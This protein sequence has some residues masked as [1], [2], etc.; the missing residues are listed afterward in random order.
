QSSAWCACKAAAMS[1]A[2]LGAFQPM[3]LH[4]TCGG[5]RLPSK[6]SHSPLSSPFASKNRRCSMLAGVPYVACLVPCEL[7]TEGSKNVRHLPRYL[8]IQGDPEFFSAYH[9]QDHVSG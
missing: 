4:I 2:F 1:A 5:W 9:H 8:S 7:L 6:T 3:H